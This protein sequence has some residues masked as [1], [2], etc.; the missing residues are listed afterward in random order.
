M[1][2]EEVRVVS[3]KTVGLL[4][5]G[6]MGVTIGA[7]AAAGGARVIWASEQRSKATND[8]A[9]RARLTDIGNLAELVRS[10]DVIL[11]VCPPHAAPEIARTVMRSNFSGIY[12]DANAVSPATAIKISE[13]VTKS[14]ASF[15][16]GGIIGSPVKRAGT[17]RLYLSG[18]RSGEV[19]AVFS[20]SLLDAK[21]VG[22]QPG[23]ASAL[24]MA[25]AAWTKC[26]DALVLGIRALAS[27]EGV[28]EALIQE[29]S[30]S[31][32]ELSPRSVKAAESSAP[33]AWRYV[34]EMKEIAA[35]FA[36]VGLP[37]GFHMAATDIY[38]R[39]E[40]FKDHTDPPP[41]LTEVVNALCTSGTKRRSRM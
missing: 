22:D 35:T 23:R 13:T 8:R 3:T 24:K 1:S 25:Y 30:L 33:K 20:G 27:M 5:P 6:N 26:S 4:H 16:D 10:S 39:L 2:L 12:V 11:A 29:W 40:S 41:S 28:E 15:V 21:V 36:D 17:T 37:S 32:P 14:G 38:E 18:A 7:A 31:Q 34:G 19:A 9:N